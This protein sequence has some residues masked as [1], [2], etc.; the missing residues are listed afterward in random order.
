MSPITPANAACFNSD[1]QEEN[2]FV[3]TDQMM[4]ID[5]GAETA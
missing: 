1:Q 5:K 2:H 4:E 3:R